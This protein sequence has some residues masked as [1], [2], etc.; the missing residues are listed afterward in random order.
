MF[1]P[2]SAV[3]TFRDPIEEV[4]RNKGGAGAL[5]GLGLLASIW[6]AS[7]YVGAFMRASNVIYE[8]KEGRRFWKLQSPPDLR[9]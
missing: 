6:S 3:D 7:A 5:L 8:V 4:V 2:R 1:A 9:V